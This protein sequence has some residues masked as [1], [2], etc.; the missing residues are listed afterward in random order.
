M[1]FDF[2]GTGLE[3][4]PLP[5]LEWLAFMRISMLHIMDF[6]KVYLFINTINSI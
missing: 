3:R 2:S 6:G 4:A 1:S 5:V